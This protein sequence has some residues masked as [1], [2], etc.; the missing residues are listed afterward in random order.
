MTYAPMS[1][2]GCVLSEGLEK[3]SFMK[4]DFRKYR[5]HFQLLSTLLEMS[6]AK[7]VQQ[8]KHMFKSWAL[9]D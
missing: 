2:L 9:F 3:T 7:Q 8:N 1:T 6:T 4:P 5:P